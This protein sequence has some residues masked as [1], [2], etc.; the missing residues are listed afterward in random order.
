[1]GIWTPVTKVS[2]IKRTDLCFMTYISS[3]IYSN[4]ALLHKILRHKKRRVARWRLPRFSGPQIVRKTLALLSR[5]QSE[6]PNLIRPFADI[7]RG[8][9]RE[10]RVQR[11]SNQYR[12]L[13]FFFHGNEII[14]LHGFKKKTQKL[15]ERDL[16]IA[17]NRMNDWSNRNQ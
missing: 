16:Q 17:E 7:V 9:I 14:L 5:L 1:M 10:L 8:K 4:S 13:Y 6:G 2:R 11:Q 12:I 15:E 3:L